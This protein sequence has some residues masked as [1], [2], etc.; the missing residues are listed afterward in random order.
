MNQKIDR[1]NLLK[2]GLMALGGIAVAPHLT[3]GAFENTPLSLDP[4][5]RIYR[6]PMVREHFL[7]NDFKA[8]KIVARLSSNENPYGPPM[9]AQK[10]VADS[11]KNGN[12]YAWKEMYDLIDK[13]AKKEGVTAEH[14]MMGPGSSDLLEKVALVTFMNGGNIVSADP[15]Y[16]SLVS[17]AKSVGATWKP[18]PCT[19]DWSHD[20]KAMEAAIDKDTKLVYVC[21]PNN[22]TGAITKGQD[23]LDFCSRV[24]EKVPVFVDEAYI[25]LAVGADT[26][27]MVS[28]LAQ[29]K[30]VIIAR[31]FSKIMG[32]AGIRVGYIAAQP[33]FLAGINKITRG[34]MGISY[35]SIFAASASLDDKD[36]QGNTR[37]LN[38]EAKTYLYENLD[39]MGYKYI[40]SYTNFV[41]FPISIPGKE[42]LSKM[43]AKGIAVRSFDVQNKPWC[44]VSIG[45]MDEMKAFVGALGALS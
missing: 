41:L 42:L 34:G 18:V 2:S 6:S 28:L 21:N 33:E 10:A 22:P 43:T 14:I 37:K 16:M 7:P 4:E 9:S 38:H 31:T 20:L 45:T 26:Q 44:R 19:A 13:I 17:V 5:N 23:L 3:A 32:M 24:S 25:E 15:C 40:P 29:K 11:V 12:R 36:F 27:S 35:T 8:P 30:N 1:R 39:K